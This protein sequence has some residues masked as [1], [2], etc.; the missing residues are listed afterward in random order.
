MISP[1]IIVITRK[2]VEVFKELNIA[3]HIGG[4]LASS[5]FGI[6]RATLDVD[7][8]AEIKSEHAT[9]IS[10]PSDG[11]ILYRSRCNTGSGCEE[12]LIQH[13]SSRYNV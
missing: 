6:P 3:Y 2:V 12:I 4:S 7:L 10:Q 9:V 8:V 11:G 1:V 13:Y 5:A